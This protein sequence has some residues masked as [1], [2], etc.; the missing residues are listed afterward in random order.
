[1][2][3]PAVFL[4]F[5]TLGHMAISWTMYLLQFRVAAWAFGSET[6][7]GVTERTLHVVSTVLLWPV[8][9]PV[10][11]FGGWAFFPG[12][13]S[14][15]PLL[16]NSVVWAFAAFWV[17]RR[18]F[19]STHLASWSKREGPLRPSLVQRWL[20]LIVLVAVGAVVGWQHVLNA[21]RVSFMARGVSIGVV[22]LVTC[23]ALVIFPALVISLVST[24]VAGYLLVTASLISVGAIAIFARGEPSYWEILAYSSAYVLGQTFLLGSGFLWLARK[25]PLFAR[26]DKPGSV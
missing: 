26:R 23:E 6:L 25:G 4:T 10:V 3:R 17:L 7:G 16:V 13:L 18:F 15:V 1:M 11:R 8:F 20:A 5:F 22:A 2:G 24:R 21:G 12:S 9:D 14:Y 19:P